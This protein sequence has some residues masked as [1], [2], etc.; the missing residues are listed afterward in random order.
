MAAACLWIGSAGMLT[1]PPTVKAIW[2]QIL[3]PDR[4]PSPRTGS[5]CANCWSDWESFARI[6]YNDEMLSHI[7]RKLLNTVRLA[8]TT[9]E[10]YGMIEIINNTITILKRPSPCFGVKSL[11]GS[12]SPCRG[13]R[14]RIS[15]YGPRECRGTGARRH[16]SFLR[17]A[18]GRFVPFLPG[19]FHP[20][21]S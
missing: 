20:A 2:C 6:P 16:I 14:G 3:I 11:F 4:N 17:S 7:F 10:N 15:G 8:L 12:G 5:P 9:F 19:P 21:G 13:T 1:A 18:S